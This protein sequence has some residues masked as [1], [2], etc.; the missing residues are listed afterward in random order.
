MHTP[1]RWQPGPAK[2]SACHSPPGKS[3][4][5]VWQGTGL[6]GRSDESTRGARVAGW[7]KGRPTLCRGALLEQELTPR[8]L[9]ELQA[10]AVLDLARRDDVVAD[11]GSR[12]Q[13]E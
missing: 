9:H 10:N 3:G 4:S 6:D 2:W 11:A 7:S 8:A 13:H 12:S 1:S 5:D